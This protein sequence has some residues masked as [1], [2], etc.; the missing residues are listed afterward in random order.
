MKLIYFSSSLII[1]HVWHCL[2]TW[3]ECIVRLCAWLLLYRHVS[4]L[5][6]DWCL[7]SSSSKHCVQAVI[8]SICN[9]WFKRFLSE[10][11]YMRALSRRWYEFAT[12]IW[13]DDASSTCRPLHAVFVL[14]E[15]RELIWFWS[16]DLIVSSITMIWN[17]QNVKRW[18]L[19]EVRANVLS[20]W[21]SLLSLKSMSIISSF[22]A[23]FMSMLSL[24]CLTMHKRLNELKEMTCLQ[25]AWSYCRSNESYSEIRNFRVIFW[26][27]IACRWSDF[28]NS[29]PRNA[30]DKVSSSI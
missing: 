6:S 22:D 8:D 20:S 18:L 23:S 9:I 10:K 25:S 24:T 29:S 7:T 4:S 13:N 27:K 26:W 17:Y 16:K 28:C 1:E 21:L 30:C 11:Q 3:D 15:S 5:S 19:H 2:Q 12:S 14:F